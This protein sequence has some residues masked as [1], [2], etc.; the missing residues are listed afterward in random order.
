MALQ[1]SLAVCRAIGNGKVSLETWEHNGC[2]ARKNFNLKRGDDAKFGLFIFNSL[3]TPTRC[4]Q[5]AL[6]VKLAENRLF[7]SNI[8]PVVVLIMFL[9]G[10]VSALA[11]AQVITRGRLGC[12]CI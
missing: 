2:L 5:D 8:L 3:K 11:K 10:S 4:L 12:K 6:P 9:A 1:G 7:N